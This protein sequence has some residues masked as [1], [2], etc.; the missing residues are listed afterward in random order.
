MTRLLRLMRLG[1]VR[2]RGALRKQHWLRLV[3]L[4]Q[5]RL[6]LG[7]SE[8]RVKRESLLVTMRSRLTNRVDH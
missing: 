2:R 5:V 3:K 6:L 1:Q 7:F 4:S 8:K